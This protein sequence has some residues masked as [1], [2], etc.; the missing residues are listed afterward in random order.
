MKRVFPGLRGRPLMA[1][2]P[3][4]VGLTLMG[5]SG[6]PAP[7][8]DPAGGATS[9]KTASPT[10]VAPPFRHPLPGMPAVI[11]NDVYAAA[12]AG[13]VSAAIKHEPAYLYVPNAE[14]APHTTVI[15]QRTHRVV[16]ILQSGALSQHVTPSWDLKSLY[17]EASVS[18][19]L[20]VVDP[21]SGQMTRTIAVRRPYN[22]YFSPDGKQGIVMEEQDNAIVFTNPRTFKPIA[23][24]S[25][26][27]C[28][29][30]NHADFSGNGRYFVVTCEFSGSLLK[31]STLHHKVTGRL[32]LGPGSKP[33]DVRL[34]PD[35]RTFYVADMGRNLLL[36]LR[37]DRFKV[38]DISEPQRQ[39]AVCVGSSGGLGQRY[40]TGHQQDCCHLADACRW[41]AR[42]GWGLG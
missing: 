34:S 25:D 24:V 41:D 35:G 26:P 11:D 39:T 15:D 27:S 8:S 23:T 13:M 37:W 36:R 5:C 3:V 16:R 17:V 2:I 20:A 18:N 32:A 19:H 10:P 14:G 12:R 1:A 29:G 38:E 42:H 30:P 33:Q 7:R 21:T 31:V 40:F 28:R 6:T 22:L 4:L 9:T